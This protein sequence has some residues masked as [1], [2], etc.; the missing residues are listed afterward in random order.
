MVI[1][2]AAYFNIAMNDSCVNNNE[3]CQI[4]A[5]IWASRNGTKNVHLFKDLFSDKQ[6]VKLPSTWYVIHEIVGYFVG[7]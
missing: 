1:P 6:N 3:I 4:L 7:Q 2:L 5:A